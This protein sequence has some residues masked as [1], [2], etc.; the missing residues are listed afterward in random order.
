[1]PVPITRFSLALWFCLVLSSVESFINKCG[2]MPIF[3]FA[4]TVYSIYIHTY[5]YVYWFLLRTTIDPLQDERFSHQ[6]LFSIITNS[7]WKLIHKKWC[8]KLSNGCIAINAHHTLEW[9]VLQWNI[10]NDWMIVQNDGGMLPSSTTY[11]GGLG[12]VVGSHG[13]HHVR[14]SLPDMG[15]APSEPPKL[16]PYHLLVITNYRLPA[17]VD[18]CNLE[19]SYREISFA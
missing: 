11:T 6:F 3:F 7:L 14:R 15:T 2:V 19:V 18:R 1:M 9:I 4:A 10:I 17:D 8:E 12:S 16:Y 13:G 5:I